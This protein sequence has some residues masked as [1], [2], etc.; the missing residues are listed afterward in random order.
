[1][2]AC[3]INTTL[4]VLTATNAQAY[5]STAP[6]TCDTQ[7]L[8][9]GYQ[10]SSELP[11]F[12]CM[13]GVHDVQTGVKRYT[14][15]RPLNDPQL[16]PQYSTK[17]AYHKSQMAGNTPRELWSPCWIASPRCLHNWTWTTQAA[18]YTG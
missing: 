10:P 4:V 11:N 15:R 8:C 18:V 9:T 12:P 14:T 16:T 1:M 13:D 17:Q 2:D 6:S 5:T 3:P 7:T